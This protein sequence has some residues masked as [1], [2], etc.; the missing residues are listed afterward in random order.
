MGINK[1]DHLQ[2]VHVVEAN[3][4]STLE[5]AESTLATVLDQVRDHL[6]SLRDAIQE[7]QWTIGGYQ[8]AMV[9]WKPAH[10]LKAC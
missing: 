10:F 9:C 1:N 4:L 8:R 7:S 5:T 6:T 3:L 2:P